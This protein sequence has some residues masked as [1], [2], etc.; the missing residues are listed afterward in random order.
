[1]MLRRAFLAATFACGPALAAD[2][3]PPADPARGQQIAAG[4]C[5]ACHGPDGNSPTPENPK[6]AGQIPEYLTKQLM[7]FR[8]A[9]PGRQPERNNAVMLGFASTLSVEDMRNVAAFYSRQTLK[10]SRA[11]NHDT[12]EI[13]QRIYRGGIAERGVPA[14]AGCHGPAG[15]GIPAQFPLLGGQY[16]QYIESQLKAFRDGVRHNDPNKMMRM[17]A[18]RLSDAEIKALAD[19]IAGVRAP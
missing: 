5:A 11:T 8:P 13:G 9:A 14:C 15:A 1:M 17:S 18:A 16:A 19:Y 10:P 7:N 3:L 6:L 4:V 2:S 12:V